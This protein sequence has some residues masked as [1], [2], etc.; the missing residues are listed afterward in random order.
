MDK[1]MSA[2]ISSNME[3]YLETIHLL[4]QERRIVRVKDIAAELN[5]TMPSVSSA[6]KNLENLG[7]VSHSRYDS[8]GL[9]EKGTQI[10]EAVYKRHRVIKYFLSAVLGLDS[11]IA[12]KDACRIEHNISEETMN[13]LMQFLERIENGQKPSPMIKG[14]L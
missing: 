8:V 10:A 5:I 3:D 2:H 1:K 14:S 11:D 4:E 13:K 12:E 7:L 6:V 9:T